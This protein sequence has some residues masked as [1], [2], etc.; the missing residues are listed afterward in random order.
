MTVANTRKTAQGL[1]YAATLL[2]VF[3]AAAV[4]FGGVPLVPVVFAQILVFFF[5][6]ID[7][8]I[9]RHLR[10]PKLSL[11]AIKWLAFLLLYSVFSSLFLPILFEGIPVLSPNLGIDEQI[12]S[13]TPLSLGR[14]NLAQTVY[15]FLNC[16]IV[17]ASCHFYDPSFVK[18][19]SIFWVSSGLVI[20][21]F[22]FYQKFSQ[23]FGLYFPTNIIYS[24]DSYS[25]GSEQQLGTYQ[26]IS[27]TFTEPSN[28]GNVLGSYFSY[29][30]FRL[31]QRL[32]I[33]FV[34]LALIFFVAVVMTSS[35]VG[36]CEI[37]FSFIW[38]L[39]GAFKKPLIALII[40][41]ASVCIF[42]VTLAVAPDLIQLVIVDKSDSL[43]FANRIASD[44]FSLKLF[45]GTYLLG[46]GLGSNRPSSFATYL[47]S[48]IGLLGTVLFCVYT[49]RLFR[50]N[51]Q[52]N[53]RSTIKFRALSFALLTL[54]VGKIVGVPDPNSWFLWITMA[55]MA[56][57]KASSSLDKNAF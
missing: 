41:S 16:A 28:A 42:F 40:F 12:G 3:Q 35:S 9:R 20:V 44:I 50:L 7:V 4:N 46:T 19:F 24:N 52:Y 48:N 39:L 54:L 25:V 33:I 2:C 29:F 22:C 56:S 32:T 26:R 11:G 18:K 30:L 13:P 31:T 57:L 15:L 17:F 36:Y 1:I 55:L 38:I 27:A 45:T 6:V 14:G 43:S 53:P 21:F 8:I 23:V 34:A 51:D 5:L 37:A 47:I 49:Y 10:A